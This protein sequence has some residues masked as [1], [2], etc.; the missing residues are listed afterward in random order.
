MICCC[1]CESVAK[2]HLQRLERIY[3]TGNEII[4]ISK[5]LQDIEQMMLYVG[6]IKDSPMADAALDVAI[7]IH[8]EPDDTERKYAENMT[9]DSLEAV[10]IHAMDLVKKR[11]N[12]EMIT[13]K[14]K[15]KS[16]GES[17]SFYSL[18][19]RYK[20]LQR[21]VTNCSMVVCAVVAIFFLRRFL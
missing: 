18:E 1:G 15:Q 7:A 4:E 19:S 5:N 16:I 6:R 14:E 20:F 21:L 13:A 2:A 17:Y 9:M 11:A 12:L 3:H 10:K 8:G